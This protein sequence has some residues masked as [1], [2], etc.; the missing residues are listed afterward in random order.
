M[1][2]FPLILLLLALCFVILF[3]RRVNDMLLWRIDSRARPPEL[4]LVLAALVAMF[5]FSFLGFHMAL[6]RRGGAVAP[7][8]RVLM[9]VTGVVFLIYGGFACLCPLRFAITVSPRLRRVPRGDLSG[10]SATKIDLS[11]RV[12]GMIMIFASAWLLRIWF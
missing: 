6:I 3:P 4:R 7:I 1:A 5:V 11:A 10:R 8:Q 9:T 12:M 2:H